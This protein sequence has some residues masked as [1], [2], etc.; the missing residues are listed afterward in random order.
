MRLDAAE[1]EPVK[2]FGQ[3][4]RTAVNV[5]LLPVDAVRDVGRLMIDPTRI[6]DDGDSALA[7]R[8]QTLKDEA[9]DDE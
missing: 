7:D 3:L 6:I 9:G 8:I 4:V 1:G 5:V 2:I